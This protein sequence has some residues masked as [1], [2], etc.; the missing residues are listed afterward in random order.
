MS[1]ASDLRVVLHMLRGMPRSGDAASRL[2]AF[3]APQ[4]SAYDDF[5]ERLLQG[6]RELIEQLELPRCARVVELGAG[7]GRNLDHFG[8]RLNAFESV[9]LVDLCPALLAEARQR[10]A[11]FPNVRV[12]EGDA[13][14]YRPAHSVDC[15]IFS[16]S[17]TMIPD[18]NAALGNA[19]AMLK[20]GGLLA[21]VDFTVSPQQGR[22]ASLFWRAW[23]GHDGVR[24]NAEHVSALR[25]LCRDHAVEERRA[26][27]PYLPGLR[28]PYYLFIGRAGFAA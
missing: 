3:Y 26:P 18:W 8:Q 20:P 15:V 16:Y 6:R 10:A 22:L 17:L 9:D 27:I 25:G 11:P 1:A 12:V 7:T 4:A 2:Q 24:L 19:M 14:S 23:F 5:R 28:V 13:T 21:V